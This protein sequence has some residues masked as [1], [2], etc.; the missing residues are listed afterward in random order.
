[1]KL[2]SKRYFF[3]LLGETYNSYV[4]EYFK[5]IRYKGIDFIYYNSIGCLKVYD[6][7]SG[8]RRI[9]LKNVYNSGFCIIEKDNYL[10][11]LCGGQITQKIFSEHRRDKMADTYFKPVM[12]HIYQHPEMV[13]KENKELQI[14]I[15]GVYLYRSSDGINW[16]RISRSPVLHRLI[17][18]TGIKEGEI[19][20]DTMPGL[21][22]FKGKYL[23]FG[24]LNTLR[25]K[26][27]LYLTSSLDLLSWSEPKRLHILNP[28]CNRLRYSYYH[29]VPFL[30]QNRL[31][32]IAPYFECE[33]KGNYYIFSNCCHVI[34]SSEDGLQWSIQK[35]MM[36][37]PNDRCPYKDR[38]SDIVVNRGSIILYFRENL[39]LVGQK[40]Y[41]RVLELH[42]VPED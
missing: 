24:R 9:I 5:I 1:M 42:M 39:K 41:K 30:Y 13:F 11:L 31:Y 38:I 7:L 37:Q 23:Y 4:G 8:L 12:N 36:L 10:Y 34:M 3:S 22:F 16:D 32:G 40:F 25:Q 20:H 26:R 35:K 29:L 6:S 15:N 18:G 27:E 2:S 19:N 28:M 17:I 14:P 21:I 33:D